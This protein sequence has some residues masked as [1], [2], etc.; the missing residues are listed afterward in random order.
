MSYVFIGI[1]NKLLLSLSF[2]KKKIKIQVCNYTTDTTTD[3]T[4]Y[5]CAGIFLLTNEVRYT[6][7]VWCLGR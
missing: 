1:S 4:S 5:S 2:K 6:L 7:Q 3:I